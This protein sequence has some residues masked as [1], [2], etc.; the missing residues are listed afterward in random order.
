MDS[1]LF[2]TSS[3]RVPATPPSPSRTITQEL[4]DATVADESSVV[5]DAD[6][7]LVA[8][9]DEL[10]EL[11]KEEPDA[12]DEDRRHDAH[13]EIFPESVAASTNDKVHVI[14]STA[15]DDIPHLPDADKLDLDDPLPNEELKSSATSTSDV[16]PAPPKPSTP[17]HVD[18][19]PEEPA[20][21]EPEADTEPN[22]QN[23]PPPLAPSPLPSPSLSSEDLNL[24]SHDETTPGPFASP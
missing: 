24:P 9:R 7:A 20:L 2:A 13:Q 4:T 21:A 5:I 17:E 8:Q 10:A 12:E 16:D 6:D 18:V 15:A 19:I 23:D 22:N 14:S 3:S 1:I 11:P